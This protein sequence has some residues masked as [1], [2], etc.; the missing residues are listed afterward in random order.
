MLIQY[1][2]Y[3]NAWAL[4]STILYIHVPSDF[5]VKKDTQLVIVLETNNT[6]EDY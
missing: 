4:E 6:V 1:S 2:S 3:S 5:W